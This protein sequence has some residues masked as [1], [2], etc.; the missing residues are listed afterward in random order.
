[1]APLM[2][3]ICGRRLRYDRSRTLRRIGAHLVGLE[4]DDK[5]GLVRRRDVVDEV[6]PD[7]RQ[8][9]FDARDRRDDVFDLLDHRFGA[10]DRCAFGKPQGG[11]DCALVL[12]RQKALRRLAEQPCRRRQHARHDHD[13]D[14]RYAHQ[15]THDGHIAV[16]DT[17]DAAQDI[18]HEAAARLAAL[19]EHRAK[20]RTQRQGIERRD[21][22]RHRYGHGKLAEKLAADAGNE[23]HG[24]EHRQEDECDGDDRAR[25]LGHGLLAGLRH[26]QLGFLLDHPLDVLDDDDGVIDHDAD[27]EHERQ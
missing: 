8:H 17:V 23:G 24:N 27:G 16:A 12:F 11:K 21:Q 26:R 20:R 5:E 22:H 13:A 18:A 9:A 4:P 15:P 14:D 10:V 3:A 1:M 19:Q 25:D 7:H 2:A 6:Q